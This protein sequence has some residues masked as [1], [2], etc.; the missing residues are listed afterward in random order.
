MVHE[1]G[2]VVRA[3]SKPGKGLTF[4]MELPLTL[5]VI[6]TFLVEI[7]SEPYAFPLAR[8]ERCLMIDRRDIETVEDR[9][10]FRLDSKNISL[11]DIHDVLELGKPSIPQDQLRVVVVSDRMHAYGLVVDEFLGECDLVVRPL[12]TRL[13][14]VR[15]ISAAAVMLDGSPVM[16][17]DVE[18]LVRSVDSLLGGKQ[19]IRKIGHAENAEEKI[20]KH[21]LVVDDSITVREMERKL[22]ESKGYQVDVAV[23]GMD[24]WNLLRIAPYDMVVSDIDMPRMN[25]IELITHIKQ[26]DNLKSLPVMIVSYKNKEEDRLR[27]LEAGAN[28]YLTKSSFQDNSFI[29]AVA[30]LIGEP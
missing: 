4:H 30:D 25:G 14:K 9:E 10:Y 5:S 15:D 20:A 19:R 24:A 12:D 18:D 26:N 8:I 6:R 28:Y 1:V 7:T 3:V 23:D 27:G 13:G 11:V 17:F 22:L 2:G 29:E 16:I 21:I